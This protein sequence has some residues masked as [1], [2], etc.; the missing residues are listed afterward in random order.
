[1]GEEFQITDVRIEFP[2]IEVEFEFPAPIPGFEPSVIYEFAV[3]DVFEVNEGE[4]V[5]ST[6]DSI[7]YEAPDGER[8]EIDLHELVNEEMDDD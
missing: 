7:I 8:H 4:F 2:M 3:E 1:M 5:E 6:E